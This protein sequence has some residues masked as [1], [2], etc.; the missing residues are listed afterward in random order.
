M[1][2]VVRIHLTGDVELLATYDDVD[3]AIVVA[4]TQYYIFNTIIA[5]RNS[6]LTKVYWLSPNARM[7]GWNESERCINWRRNNWRIIY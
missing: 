7:E 5:V 1:Y 4:E 2:E 3:T 6:E